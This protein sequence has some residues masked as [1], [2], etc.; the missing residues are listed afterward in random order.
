[1]HT[2]QAVTGTLILAFSLILPASTLAETPSGTITIRDKDNALCS[3][4]APPSGSGLT[5]QYEFL[6]FESPCPDGKSRSITLLELPSATRILLTDDRTC[7][8]KLETIEDDDDWTRNFWF[9]LKTTKKLTTTPIEEI[10]YYNDFNVN[11]II[12]PGLQLI[13]K[14]RLNNNAQIRDKLSCVRVTASSA[15]HPPLPQPIHVT[16]GNWSAG[17]TERKSDFTC[18]GNEVMVGRKHDGDENGNTFYKCGIANPAAPFQLSERVESSVIQESNSYYMCPQ[19]KVM[20]GRSHTGDENGDTTYRCAAIKDAQGNRI[21]LVRSEWTTKVRESDS[22]MQC[23]EN[24]IM[25]GR[26]HVGDENGFTYI[27]CAQMTRV[28][29]G[30]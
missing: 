18:N 30:P 13:G 12:S 16:P 5:W 2:F 23:A 8:Q 10:D 11:Q 1:M 26:R 25:V 6:D 24:Q 29:T 3:L 27:R 4:P 28:K 9:E 21:N 14:G 7:S 19:N 20:T 17:D 15:E 22:T